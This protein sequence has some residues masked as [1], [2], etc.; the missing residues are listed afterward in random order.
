MLDSCYWWP[1][2]K[3]CPVR[4]ALGARKFVEGW[5]PHSR[6]TIIGIGHVSNQPE[7]VTQLLQ[8][9]FVRVCEY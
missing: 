8:F 3:A 2:A 5:N 7:T 4:S 1:K 6:L 9:P